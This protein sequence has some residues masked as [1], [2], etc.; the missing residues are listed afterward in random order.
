MCARLS[1]GGQSVIWTHVRIAASESEA[2]LGHGVQ[3]PSNCCFYSSAYP[4]RRIAE[5]LKQA[6][7][8]VFSRI[9]CT[10]KSHK[11]P[12]RVAPRVLHCSTGHKYEALARWIVEVIRPGIQSYRHLHKNTASK[13]VGELSPKQNSG[14][15]KFPFCS[16]KTGAARW[17]SS[18]LGL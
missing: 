17:P 11:L 15:L 3:I 9:N 12:G 2:Q 10:I 18:A 8:P 16:R 7:G 6:P 1:I 13:K 4:G 14:A 5:V